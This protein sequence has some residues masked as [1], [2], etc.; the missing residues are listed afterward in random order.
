MKTFEEYSLVIPPLWIKEAEWEEAVQEAQGAE[1]QLLLCQLRLINILKDIPDSNATPERV[2][3]LSLWAKIYGALDGARGALDRQTVV[4]LRVIDRVCF[5]W[6]LHVQ[7]ILQPALSLDK[8]ANSHAGKVTVA[9]NARQD[10]WNQAVR[11]LQGYAA[12]CLW[13]DKDCYEE[14]LHPK[15]QAGVWDPRPARELVA[16]PQG[17]AA[18]EAFFGPVDL[19]NEHDLDR[20]GATHEQAIGEALRRVSDWLADERLKPWVSKL[21]H[22]ATGE[23]GGPTFFSLLEDTAVSVPRR[24]GMTGLRFSYFQ[25]KLGSMVAHGSTLDQVLEIG[26]DSMAPAIGSLRSDPAVDA[27]SVA[28]SC[29]LSLLGLYLLEKRIWLR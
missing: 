15:T 7:A 22:G 3:W 8:L 16:D 13:S 2:A 18:H 5:E 10:A 25:Y 14:M 1:R 9:E 19:R 26:L 20:D 17:F 23:A 11:R 27:E 21:A 4:A 6:T 12:W 28:A 29:N 24:L